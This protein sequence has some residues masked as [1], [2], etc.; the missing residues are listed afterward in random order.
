MISYTDYKFYAE[1]YRGDM[2]KNSF[3]HCI[4]MA[5]QYI[6][7]ITS[8]R[9]DEYNGDELKFAACEVADIYHRYESGQ[10]V[11]S[12]NNDGYSVSYASEGET[13]ESTEQI[14]DKK[15]YQAVRKWLLA[16]GLLNRKVGSCHDN[17]CEHYPI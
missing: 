15:S 10:R 9:A 12:E 11:Q 5:S 2:D 6:R 14:R 13:G 17:Q 1:N 3:D 7:H 4:L 16:S 8:G